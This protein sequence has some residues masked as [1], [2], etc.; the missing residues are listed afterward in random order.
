MPP[1][2]SPTNGHPVAT[3]AQLKGKRVTST[4]PVMLDDDAAKAAE[5]AYKALEAA[6]RV[7]P[8]D[9]E[10]VDALTAELEVAQAAVAD[11]TVE[12]RFRSIGSKALER[13]IEKHPPTEAQIAAAQDVPDG[14]KPVLSEYNVDT[15]PVAI[16]AASATDPVMSEDDVA[17]MVEGWN[18]N[19]FLALWVAALEVNSRSRVGQMG[20][21]Y[22]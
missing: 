18:T 3:L 14:D 12:I 16:V 21:L 10:K 6:R 7:K 19:E 11:A 22:G 13:L 8:L 5:Q 1:K 9:A 4:V 20:K 2:K 15:F 17:E